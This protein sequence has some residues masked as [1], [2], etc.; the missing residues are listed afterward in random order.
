MT[1]TD[2]WAGNEW[3]SGSWQL[4]P[5]KVS[6]VARFLSGVFYFGYFMKQLQNFT[7]GTQPSGWLPH[8]AYRQCRKENPLRCDPQRGITVAPGIIWSWCRP[9]QV[10]HPFA[11]LCIVSTYYSFA[12]K[13]T[14]FRMPL[15]LYKKSCRAWMTE[16]STPMGVARKWTDIGYESCY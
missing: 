13:K 2:L 7:E 5:N 11:R 12:R 3:R 15:F 8:P 4:R 16:S 10:V 14:S 1:S 6:D 9:K